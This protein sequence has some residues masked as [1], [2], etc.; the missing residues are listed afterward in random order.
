MDHDQ[1]A[2]PDAGVERLEQ[3]IDRGGRCHVNAGAPRMGDIET[4]SDP[5]VGH[6]AVGDRCRERGQLIDVDA[7]PEATPRG[8]LEDEH[9][10]RVGRRRY[11]RLAGLRVDRADSSLD[12]DRHAPGPGLDAL[13][14][15]RPDMDVHVS[16]AEARRAPQLDGEEVDRSLEEVGIGSGQVHEVRGMDGD[17]ADVMLAQPIPEGRQLLRRLLASPP[18]GRVVGEDL[19]RVGADVVGPVD[20]LHHP[21]AQ[22]QVGAESSTVRQHGGHRT[23]PAR[24]RMRRRRGRW[25]GRDGFVTPK[26]ARG[27]AVAPG[28]RRRLAASGRS[29]SRRRDP[30]PG[31]PSWRSR[32][33]PS[34]TRR[35]RSAR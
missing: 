29:G 4:E 21:A 27:R 3:I 14:A 22:R 17:R 15:M 1:P 5:F 6:A 10:R 7:E 31:R 25:R 19:D 28:R 16:G 23:M 9:R 20:G 34:C 13:A 26:R 32:P 35:R 33:C 18:R 12:A 11:R 30:S 24:E 8:V 2:E